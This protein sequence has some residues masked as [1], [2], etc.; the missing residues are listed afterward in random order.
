MVLREDPG[1][2][3]RLSGER[4]TAAEG[5]C[6]ADGLELETGEWRPDVDADRARGG[7]GLLVLDGFV[8]R[9]VGQEHRFG[10]ELLGSGDLVR[11]WQHD[12]EDVL[13]PLRTE[14]IVLTPARLAVLDWDFAVQAAPYPEVATELSARFLQRALQLAVSLAI[15][16]HPRI[17]TRLRMLLWHLGE[18]WGKMR[19]DGVYVCVPLTHAVIADLI[20]A[21]RP[22]VTT[23]ISHLRA[24]DELRREDGGWLLRGGPPPEL[25]GLVASSSV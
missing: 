3:E 14:W 1:L 5:A 8:L 19:A 16:Q 20:A 12:G 7:Y 15:V 13:L 21:R 10:A 9:R 18:R 25:D 11:P 2:G 24:R 6:L 4:R 23:A 22:T 17:A